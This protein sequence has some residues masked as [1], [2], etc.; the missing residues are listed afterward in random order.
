MASASEAAEL[1][2]A[3]IVRFGERRIALR[4]A[5]AAVSVAGG[6]AELTLRMSPAAWRAVRRALAR[7]R[8]VRAVVTV[9][10]TDGAGN[11]SATR[12]PSIRLIR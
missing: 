10:A 4:P 2:A 5:R 3:A 8:R 11:S 7:G 6:G 9:V 12:L 1:A